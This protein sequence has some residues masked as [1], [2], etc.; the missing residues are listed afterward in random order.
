M[1]G[2]FPTSLEPLTWPGRWLETNQ[3]SK[4]AEHVSNVNC[5]GCF[6]LIQCVECKQPWQFTF[7]TCIT[8]ITGACVCAKVSRPL[9]SCQDC[10]GAKQSKAKADSVRQL[11]VLMKK[12][13]ANDLRWSSNLHWV[14]CAHPQKKQQRISICKLYIQLRAIRWIPFFKACTNRQFRAT[15]SF[16]TSWCHRIYL[17]STAFLDSNIATSLSFGCTHLRNEFIKDW[18]VLPPKGSR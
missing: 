7:D 4:Q 11:S 13:Q 5:H 15:I 1:A 12:P 10:N 14:P 9:D 6:P 16:T 18:A 17:I 8:C 3:G 2:S